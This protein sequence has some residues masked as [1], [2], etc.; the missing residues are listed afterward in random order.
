[1]KDRRSRELD[2]DEAADGGDL[3]GCSIRGLP[4]LG[5]RRRWL[6]CIS[7][8]PALHAATP[9]QIAEAWCG[10]A[11]DRC[12]PSEPR[13]ALDDQQLDDVVAY[14]RY[15]DKPSD[16]GG[17]PLWHLGPVAEGGVA[18]VIIGALLCFVLWIGESVVSS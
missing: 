11:R 2:H 16:R 15:L 14:V 12:R 9:T 10:W 3:F 8:A 17:A 13:E 18:L 7:E 6:F 5:R 1:M 4:R